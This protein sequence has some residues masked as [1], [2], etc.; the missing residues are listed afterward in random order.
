MLHRVFSPVCTYE[1]KTASI[2]PCW[3]GKHKTGLVAHHTSTQLHENTGEPWNKV[4]FGRIFPTKQRCVGLDLNNGRNP[5]YLQPVRRWQI[6][7]FVLFSGRSCTSQATNCDFAQEY[8]GA[9]R[10]CEAQIWQRKRVWDGQAQQQGGLF[11]LR[12]Q[13]PVVLHFHCDQKPLVMSNSAGCWNGAPLMRCNLKNHRASNQSQ[14]DL[15]GIFW[16]TLCQRLRK[17]GVWSFEVTCHTGHRRSRGIE[18]HCSEGQSPQ[19]LLFGM[20]VQQARVWECRGRE[21]NSG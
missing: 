1:E 6:C 17:A 14:A 10:P 9:W 21:G 2:Q 20:Q 16:A 13:G 11:E 12:L 15:T 19:W 4:F 8:L 5:C 3:N 7:K 18:V